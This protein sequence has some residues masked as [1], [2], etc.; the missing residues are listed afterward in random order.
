M[1]GRALMKAQTEEVPG[2]PGNANHNCGVDACERKHEWQD[3]FWIDLSGR[4]RTLH[5]INI[6]W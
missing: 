4:K 5:L 3:H 1:K 2:C 6:K